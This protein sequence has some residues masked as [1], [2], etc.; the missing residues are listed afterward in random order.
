MAYP[1]VS[2]I[3]AL[4]KYSVKLAHADRKIGLGCL[5][6]QVIMIRHQTIRMTDPAVARYDM[7]EGLKKQL[8]VAVVEKD[9]LARI[10]PTSQ[11][12]NCAGKFQPKWPCHGGLLSS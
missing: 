12:I 7:S 5:N 10:T 8:A 6:Q 4:C 2:A 11:M 3:E 9:L 1:S